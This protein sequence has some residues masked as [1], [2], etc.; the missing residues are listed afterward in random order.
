MSKEKKVVTIIK[1]EIDGKQYTFSGVQPTA[2]GH[3]EFVNLN[4]EKQLQ[5]LSPED[6]AMIVAKLIKAHRDV[7]EGRISVD[8]Q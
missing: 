4:E 6:T 1:A 3:L 7:T 5:G 8:K 2:T